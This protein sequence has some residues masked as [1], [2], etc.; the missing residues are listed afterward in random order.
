[1]S[2]GREHE[3]VVLEA[4]PARLPFRWRGVVTGLL[5]VAGLPAYAV[6][7]ATVSLWV[8]QHWAAELGFYL[9]AGL[10]W[11]WPAARLG[12]WAGRERR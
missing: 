11:L 8:P 7:V 2:A 10:L 1:V 6:L 3:P 9:A 4:V 12:A 5:I